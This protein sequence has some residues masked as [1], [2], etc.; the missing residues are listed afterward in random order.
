MKIETIQRPPQLCICGAHEV[1]LP[2][3]GM[4]VTKCEEEAPTDGQRV[5]LVTM[6]DENYEIV[7]RCRA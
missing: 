2:L 5:W 4:D 6:A 1:W 3:L 7:V